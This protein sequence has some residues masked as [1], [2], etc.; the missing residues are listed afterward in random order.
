MPLLGVAAT[1]AEQ[2]APPAATDKD[3]PK[4]EP[5]KSKLE[6]MLEKALHDNPDLRLA[7]AKVA[8]AEAE[9]N[10]ARLQVVQNVAVQYHAIESQ[11]AVVQSAAAE[12]TR[13]KQ[14]QA[15]G[16]VEPAVV[17]P[18]E[19][20]LIDAKAKLA[21][22][23]AELPYLLGK[24]PDNVRLK[25]SD[26]LRAI[27]LQDGVTAELYRRWMLDEARAFGP[28]G[29]LAVQGP[30]ADR[31]RAA[32]DK[33]FTY[34]GKAAQLDDLVLAL[35]N[36]FEKDNPGL[37]INVNSIGKIEVEDSPLPP[38]RFDHVPFGAALEW[39]EDSL[40]DCRVVVRDYGV[41][42]AP[43]DQLP[44][45]APLL[46]DFWKGGKAE[47]KDAT[48]PEAKDQPAKTVEGQ[49]K[50]VDKDG[51]IRIDI[52]KNAGLAKG[53]VLTVLRIRQETEVPLYLPVGRIRVV[54]VGD[55]DAVAEPA[56]KANLAIRPGD[57]V[58]VK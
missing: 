39:I 32:L 1:W 36:A 9:L 12:L 42:I 58:R 8:E 41:A 54:E 13:I 55:C 51:R 24:E 18:A 10:R 2:P 27:S 20:K 28:D 47:D 17:E 26:A 22:L 31:I 33:P 57:I 46:H 4:E 23:E 14:L 34:D 5:A 56:E 21:S 30:T 52:G 16:T 29:K 50:D 37:L 48:K 44:P 11:K 53:D 43:K 40:P 45:G 3:K 19:Q 6:E 38:Y 49:V 15:A 35:K 25:A 7:Q